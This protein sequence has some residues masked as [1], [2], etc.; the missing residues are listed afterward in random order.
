MKVYLHIWIETNRKVPML[1][2]KPQP[3]NARGDEKVPHEIV[4]GR[5]GVLQKLC[6]E[7]EGR[8]ACDW[9]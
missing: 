2:E 7:E 9:A 3:K 5:K 4:C 6:R 8:M 1:V